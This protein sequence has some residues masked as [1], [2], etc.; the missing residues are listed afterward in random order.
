MPNTKH[1]STRHA[2]GPSS[3]YVKRRE[4]LGDLARHLESTPCASVT[5]PRSTSMM[6]RRP[7]VPCLTDI[8]HAVAEMKRVQQ[9]T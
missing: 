9:Q 1:I 5:T 2:T 7:V 4:D 6:S 3:I 8:D